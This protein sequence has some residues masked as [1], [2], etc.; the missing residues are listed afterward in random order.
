RRPASSVASARE[1]GADEVGARAEFPVALRVS[2]HR[3]LSLRYGENPHQ[4]AAFYQVVGEP[5]VGLAG[6]KPLHGPELGYNNVLD[7]SAAL[8][9]LLEFDEPAAVV[10]KH[11]NPCGVA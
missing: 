7:F 9:L 10:I 5:A 6:M 8:G 2:L 1:G 3:S 11:T 4:A